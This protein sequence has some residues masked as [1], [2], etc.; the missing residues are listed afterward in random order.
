MSATTVPARRLPRLGGFSPTVLGLELRRMMRNKRAMIFTLIMPCALYL[1]FGSNGTLRNQDLG[2]G[3]GNYS[4]AVMVSMAMY[5]A[6]IAC[7]SGGATVSV[8]RAAG[9]SRQLRLTPLNP[10]AYVTMKIL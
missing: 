1:T 3:L 4:A 9:W 8:E 10:G 6:M 5:G 7:T 2:N